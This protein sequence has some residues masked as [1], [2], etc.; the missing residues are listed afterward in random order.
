M[1]VADLDELPS[2]LR[3]AYLGPGSSAR[4]IQRVLTKAVNWYAANN[5]PIP[6]HLLFND[7]SHQNGLRDPE[8]LPS[9]P[10][11]TDLRKVEL[12]AMAP[13]STQRAIIEHYFK[14][15]APEYSLLPLAQESAALTHEN[16]LKWMSGNKDDPTAS[17]V[18]IMFAISTA[19]ITRDFD[20]HLANLSM[21][22]K[23][24]VQKL[25]LGD[26]TSQNHLTTCTALCALALLELICPTSGQLWDVL[27]RAASTMED[28]QE[29]LVVQSSARD[30][31]L[32][33]LER[34]MLK[35]ER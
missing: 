26:A 28:L 27:G 30:T 4:L 23:E 22:C 32:Q 35:L 25:S 16:P 8:I 1:E 9:F 14:V 2:P 33:R 10:V 5:I 21:R 17:A 12:Y 7:Q 15:V 20:S 31:E 18:L 29:G 11:T 24:D 3:T 13:P 6:G 19:L 34:A